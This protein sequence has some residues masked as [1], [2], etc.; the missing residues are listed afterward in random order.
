MV[1][2]EE[3]WIGDILR[4][5]KSGKIG[6]F[7]GL[8]EDKRLR[9]RVGEKV[10]VFKHD[11]LE[12]VDESKFYKK[13][14]KFREEELSVKLGNEP[15]DK[16]IDLHIEKLN[17]NLVSAIPERIVD[18]QLKS[19]EKYLDAVIANKHRVAT[20]IHGKGTGVLK[21]AIHSLLGSID[22][23]S[24]FHLINNGG[25]TEVFFKV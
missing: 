18:F 19:F 5:K 13:E 2:A 1:N 8:K 16:S 21:A 10:Y 23:V 14:V 7:E 9:V 4:S 12:K 20:I 6:K 3:L 24:H 15:V 11:Q 25:A 17:A 22:E